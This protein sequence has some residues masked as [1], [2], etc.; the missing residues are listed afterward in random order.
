MTQ[1]QICYSIYV[2]LYMLYLYMYI[3]VLF[4]LILFLSYY[5]ISLYVWTHLFHRMP[6]KDFQRTLQKSFPFVRSHS[7]HSGCLP[8]ATHLLEVNTTKPKPTQRS[9]EKKLIVPMAMVHHVPDVSS[10]Y[11]SGLVGHDIFKHSN[12]LA[13]FCA[14][15]L[16]KK[17]MIQKL[18]RWNK[19]K[20]TGVI[21]GHLLLQISLMGLHL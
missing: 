18:R 17:M 6:S 13:W 16:W 19:L 1:W 9:S 20:S 12:Y 15:G 4:F 11:I 10:W 14:G 7:W 21:P 2:I 3:Y 8:L 5:Y